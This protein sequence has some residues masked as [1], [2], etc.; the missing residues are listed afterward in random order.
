MTSTSFNIK[1]DLFYIILEEIT[2]SQLRTLFSKTSDRRD[3]NSRDAYFEG[4]GIEN[5][6]PDANARDAKSKGR[7]GTR[8]PNFSRD[9]SL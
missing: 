2:R 6:S 5:P 3:G 4:R 9:A 1:I 7:D 8:D